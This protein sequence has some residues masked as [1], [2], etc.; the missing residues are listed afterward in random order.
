MKERLSFEKPCV[1]YQKS[2]LLF[3]DSV[4][5]N[6]IHSFD[7]EDCGYRTTQVVKVK[8]FFFRDFRV[9]FWGIFWGVFL[10]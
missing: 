4:N 7:Y 1:S 3:T 2:A 5:C 8:F 6:C 9:V 10:F